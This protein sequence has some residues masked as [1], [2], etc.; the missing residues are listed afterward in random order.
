MEQLNAFWELVVDVWSRGTL[1]VDFTRIGVALC[2]FLGFLLIR[3]LFTRFVLGRIH[4]FTEKTNTDLDKTI[5][6]SVEQPVRF[7]PVVMGAFFAIDYLNLTGAVEEAGQDLVRS[8]IVFNIFWVF[9]RLVDPMSFLLG[10]L[11]RAFTNAMVDW[12]LK[13]IKVLVALIGAATILEIWGVKVGPILAGMGLF[14]VAVALGAQDLFKNL[15][16]GLLILAEKRFSI[17]DWVRVDGIVEGTVEG[18]GFRSTLVRR[19]DNAPVQVPNAALADN[20]V[21]NFSRMRRRRIY[22]MIGVEYRTT[23]DQLRRIRDEIEAYLSESDAF[24]PK[25]KAATFVRIDRFNDSSIDIM[26]YCFTRTTNWGEWLK[27]K[28]ELAYKVKQ[29][30]EGAGTGFAFPSQSLYLEQLPDAADKAEPFTP[31]DDDKLKVG[32]TAPSKSD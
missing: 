8:L 23:V 4:A 22:W 2:I 26:L 15:I 16:A 12:L 30:V 20:P 21:T 14:G 10:K 31:P 3:R 28:E 13:A 11:E 1:G 9:Y 27:V 17:G 25:D 18:I 6:T 7:A 29:V 32:F 5:L 24:V 19:F